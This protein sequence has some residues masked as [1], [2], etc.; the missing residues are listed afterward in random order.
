MVEFRS[1]LFVLSFFFFLIFFFFPRSF[2]A[3]HSFFCLLPFFSFFFFLPLSWCLTF[4]NSLSKFLH[5]S[6]HIMGDRFLSSPMKSA[7]TSACSTSAWTHVL[8]LVLD[9]CLSL[10]LGALTSTSTSRSSSPPLLS[11]RIICWCW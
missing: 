10:L 11:P 7:P 1:V 5:L 8:A 6:V 4:L 3:S 9:P 2:S